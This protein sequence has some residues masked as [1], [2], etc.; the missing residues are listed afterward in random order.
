MRHILA[1]FF[2]SGGFF[3]FCDRSRAPAFSRVAVACKSKMDAPPPFSGWGI[4]F[5]ME[6]MC[7]ILDCNYALYSQT[8]LALQ[9]VFQLVTQPALADSP[10]SK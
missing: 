10:H 9:L 1:L 2:V 5:A 7:G 6:M 8:M 3:A 4:A